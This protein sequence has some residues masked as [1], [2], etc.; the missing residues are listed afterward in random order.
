MLAKTIQSYEIGENLKSQFLA[1][2]QKPLLSHQ[3]LF[4]TDKNDSQA[5][6]I[7]CKFFSLSCLIFFHLVSFNS[8]LLLSFICFILT[9]FNA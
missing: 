2:E 4:V 7:W 1:V 5:F 6:S 9:V 3:S 8:F